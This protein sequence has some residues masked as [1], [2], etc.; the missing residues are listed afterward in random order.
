MSGFF[1]C[2]NLI[3]LRV[4]L[5]LLAGG[6]VLFALGPA[7]LIPPEDAVITHFFHQR[8]RAVD[9]IF[10]QP[11]AGLRFAIAAVAPELVSVVILG[12]VV[13]LVMNS[14]WSARINATN[15][16]LILSFYEQERRRE[17]RELSLQDYSD[18]KSVV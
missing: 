17:Q 13:L 4:L 14:F 8:L 18:R 1:S 6:I 11:F 2:H 9:V 15:L 12:L 5:N 10:L 7:E 16:L 3:S